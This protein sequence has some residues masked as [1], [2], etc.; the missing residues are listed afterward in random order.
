MTQFPLKLV[1]GM[2]LYG[3]SSQYVLPIQHSETTGMPR[4]KLSQNSSVFH[5]SEVGVFE[6]KVIGTTSAQATYFECLK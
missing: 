6:Q 4:T 5:G 1:D 3:T 2:C